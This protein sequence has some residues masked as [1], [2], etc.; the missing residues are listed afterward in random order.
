MDRFQEQVEQKLV[1]LK[2]TMQSFERM[3]NVWA[4]LAKQSSD[5]TENANRSRGQTRLAGVSRLAGE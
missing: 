1:E 4:T 2:R 5:V 3:V